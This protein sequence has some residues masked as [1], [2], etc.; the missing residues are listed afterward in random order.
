MKWAIR[1]PD[2]ANIGR[3]FFVYIHP[4][5]VMITTCSLRTSLLPQVVDD[6]MHRK[7]NGHQVH[8][9]ELPMQGVQLDVMCTRV[10]VEAK[11]GVNFFGGL[12]LYVF[13]HQFC[14]F[15]LIIY[16]AIV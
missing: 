9:C 12:C 16:T 10:N 6:L 13:L 11:K 5:K 3:E 4:K 14:V 2:I 1:I 8:C 15:V 7:L